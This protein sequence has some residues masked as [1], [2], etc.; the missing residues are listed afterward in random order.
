[1]SHFVTWILTGCRIL[2]GWQWC[3]WYRYVGDFMMVT[4]LRC[5]WQNHYVGD[6][7]HY[8][9]DF[10]N[11]LNRSSTSWIGHQHLKLVTNTFDLQNPVWTWS[12][13]F[14]NKL[15]RNRDLFWNFLFLVYFLLTFQVQP[16]FLI[17][18]QH[19]NIVN[20]TVFL[21]F[22]KYRP[23]YKWTNRK[24]IFNKSQNQS[25]IG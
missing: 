1:M 18:K 12:F 3:W 2:Y 25:K 24:L 15:R 20:N 7:F 19:S 13:N 6:F 11:V 4:D 10:L 5:W 8:V 21:P 14:T 16:V 22:K 23:T 17:C 9:G